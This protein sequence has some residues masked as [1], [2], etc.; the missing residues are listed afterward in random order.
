MLGVEL[1]P[2]GASSEDTEEE[3]ASDSVGDKSRYDTHHGPTSVIL[4]DV[5]LRRVESLTIVVLYYH[6]GLFCKNVC[7]A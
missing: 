1:L 3:V 4:L 5:F 6:P 7:V 2:Q